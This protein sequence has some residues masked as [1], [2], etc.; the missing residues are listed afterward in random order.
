MLINKNKIVLSLLLF[1][2]FSFCLSAGFLDS[3][4][5]ALDTFNDTHDTYKDTRESVRDAKNTAKNDTT[6]VI[7]TEGYT[8]AVFTTE[9]QTTE[10]FQ[11]HPEPIAFYIAINNEQQ[12]PFSL[13]VLKNQIIDKE[14]DKNTLV[15]KKG[16]SG[17]TKAGEVPVIN[18]LFKAIP[19]P[20][21]PHSLSLPPPLP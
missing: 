14:I 19:P 21:P 16:M 6:E 3:F 11:P 12:G 1:I 7:T 13:D 17:W 5:D 8:K 2:G 20:L 4:N 9:N 18:S 10:S 15:W